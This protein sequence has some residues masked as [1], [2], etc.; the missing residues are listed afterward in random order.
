[1]TNVR[2]RP[3]YTQS[4]IYEMNMTESEEE[5]YPELNQSEFSKR[6]LSRLN[7]IFYELF[8]YLQNEDYKMENDAYS[9]LDQLKE[10]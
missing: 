5:N 3:T 2:C 10:T 6:V 8:D 1:M 9:F 7:H 4:E